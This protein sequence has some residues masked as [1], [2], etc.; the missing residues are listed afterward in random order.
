MRNNGEGIYAWIDGLE[1]VIHDVNGVVIA[2]FGGVW[3]ASEEGDNG[4]WGGRGCCWGGD[5]IFI[6]KQDGGCVLFEATKGVRAVM[7]GCVW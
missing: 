2:D 4:V 5:K 7:I 1:C 6:L 3:M